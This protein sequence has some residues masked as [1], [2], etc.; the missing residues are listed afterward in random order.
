[1]TWTRSVASP[2][3]WVA[4]LFFALMIG[5]PQTAPLFAEAFPQ[6]SPPVFDRDTFIALWLSH[7]GMVLVASGA[8]A[9]VGIG[10]AIFVTR[11]A[12]E[13]LRI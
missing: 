1:M 8:A 3:L 13:Y 2:V 10:L 6:V 11:P 9:L 4:L 5:M 7:A 12:G